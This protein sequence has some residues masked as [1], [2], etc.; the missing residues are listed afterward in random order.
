MNL[1]GTHNW[2]M[3][4]GGLQPVL[5]GPSLMVSRGLGTSSCLRT[6]GFYGAR[7]VA[8]QPQALES[9]RSSSIGS[10]ACDNYVSP[11]VNETARPQKSAGFFQGFW[12]YLAEYGTIIGE[13]RYPYWRM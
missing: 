11:A 1:L 3:I 9:D 12:K 4:N 13:G 8:L 6:G 10:T 7:S 5:A 2:L